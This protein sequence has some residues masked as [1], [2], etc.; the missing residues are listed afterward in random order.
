MSIGDED[1][2][3]E[4][5]IR[6]GVTFQ[7]RMQ[8]HHQVVSVEQGVTHGGATMRMDVPDLAGS[9]GTGGLLE[10]TGSKRGFCQEVGVL[11]GLCV[12]ELVGIHGLITK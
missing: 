2:H 10:A 3:E 8:L 6:S 7:N 1:M 9:R 4:P 12:L 5:V 11:H